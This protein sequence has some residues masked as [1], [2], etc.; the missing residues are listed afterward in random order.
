VGTIK[1]NFGLDIVRALAICLV[2]GTHLIGKILTPDLPG[3]WYLAFLGVDIFFALSGFLIGDILIKMVVDSEGLTPRRTWYFLLRRW[4]RTVPLYIV[5]LIVTWLVLR[6]VFNYPDKFDYRY[7]FWLQNFSRPLN[8]FFAESWSLSVEEWFYFLFAAGLFLFV[9]IIGRSGQP[10]KYKLLAFTTGYIVLFN[11]FRFFGSSYDYAEFTIVL[12][13]QDSIAY[14]V[15]MAVIY[16]YFPFE[17][18]RM[19]RWPAGMVLSIAGILLFLFRSKTGH[20][21]LLYYPLTG[22]GLAIIVM[23]M[24]I[25]SGRFERFFLRSW[26]TVISK[27]SYS[28]YLVNVIIIQLCLLAFKPQ[29]FMERS[30]L[31]AGACVIILVVSGI[32][33]RLIEKPFLQLRDRL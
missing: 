12:F 22:T 4:F 5:M 32:T 18:W 24:K 15:L 19:L 7:F 6:I 1:R 9:K 29:S 20:A 21:Y 33:Y 10:L 2:L 28:V 14:G 27:I 26:V 3:L 11:L 25:M 13:R 16:N 8:G 31:A 23:N 17:K 30:L